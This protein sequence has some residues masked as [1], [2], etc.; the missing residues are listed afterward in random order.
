MLTNIWLLA[1]RW[2]YFPD[3]LQETW[4]SH[5]SSLLV[6]CAAAW[7]SGCEN[8]VCSFCARAVQKALCSD[9]RDRIETACF[10]SLHG[11]QHDWRLSRPTAGFVGVRN[12][13]VKF[14]RFWSCLLLW[15]HLFWSEVVGKLL[16]QRPDSKCFRQHR[17][18]G[19]CHNYFI[20]PL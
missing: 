14:L 15:H 16:L 11:E 10:V 3:P 8:T 7:A 4:W 5:L 13:C 19:L 12:K 20:L 1:Y 2:L 17:S 9:G 6:G 18:Y